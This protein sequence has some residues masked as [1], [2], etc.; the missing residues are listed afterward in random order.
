MVDRLNIKVSTRG[1]KK[2]HTGV[3]WTENVAIE[4]ERHQKKRGCAR[5]EEDGGHVINFSTASLENNNPALK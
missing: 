3:K 4:V 1:T 2:V 5:D